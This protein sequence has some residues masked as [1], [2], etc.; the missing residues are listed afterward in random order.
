MGLL[1]GLLG[2]PLA[3]VKATVWVAEQ[4][5]REAEQQ[6][7]DPERIRQELEEIDQLRQDGAI[8]TA[9][10]EQWED[11]LIARFV[12]DQHDGSTGGEMP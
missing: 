10:A 11:E 9:T 4:V 6:L 12:Q 7:N 5:R 2:L 3:P 8:D 1:S